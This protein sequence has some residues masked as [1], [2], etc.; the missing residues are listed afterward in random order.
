MPGSSESQVQ[1]HVSDYI[2]INVLD[3]GLGFKNKKTKDLIKPYF[4]TKEKGT[5]LGLS[6]VGKIVSDHNGSIKLLNHKYGAKIQLIFQ[7]KNDN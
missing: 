3:T 4:T 6:I 1:F 2:I 7:R 5:G